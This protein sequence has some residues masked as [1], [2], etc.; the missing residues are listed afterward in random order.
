MNFNFLEGDLTPYVTGGVGWSFID[1]N[2]P[3]APPQTRV[4]VGSV[5]GLLLRHV[6]EHAQH[7]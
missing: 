4:L 7:R 6:A 5:V 1:T 3:D 2:I